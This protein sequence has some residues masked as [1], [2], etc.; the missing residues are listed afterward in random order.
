MTADA[1]LSSG[2]PHSFGGCCLDVDNIRSNPA[3]SSKY[4]L[5]LREKRCQ[6]RGLT[7][8]SD[9]GINHR[10]PFVP[11]ELDDTFEEGNGIDALKLGIGIGE[12]FADISTPQSPEE[13]VA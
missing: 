13:G 8:Q 2:K 4:L 3:G 11:D 6:P 7:D 10:I 5:H 12:K 9:V 1:F